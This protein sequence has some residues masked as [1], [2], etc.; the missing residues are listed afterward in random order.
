MSDQQTF[1]EVVT[2]TPVR[3]ITL[4]GDA[5]VL[6]L[7]TLDNGFDHTKPNTFGPQTIA[8]LLDVVQELHVRAEAG[9]IQAVGITGK[10]FIFAVGADLKAVA[11]ATSREQALEVAR[12]GHAA[13]GAIMDLPVPTFA[14]VNGAAMGGGV[15]IALSADYRSISAGVPAIAL[16]E[17]FLG[18]VPGWGGC[19]LLPNLVGPA[20]ALKVIIENPMNTNRML[21]GPQAFE[22]GMA[23]VMF[24]PAD[25]LEESLLWAAKVITGETTVERTTKDGNGISRDESEWSGAIK[26]AKGL[27]DLKTGG[28]SPAPYRALQL[29]AAARTATRDEAF[30]AEDEALADLVMGDELRAGLYSF[31]LVQRRAKRPAGAPDKALARKVTKVGIVGAGLM[32]SQLALLFAQRLEVPVVMTDLDEERVGQGRGLRPRRG[33]QA[34]RQA[35]GQP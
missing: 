10:P 11:Q 9:E 21:K 30:A 26:A 1:D 29:V 34:A 4:P 16:P 33:R 13:F 28:K 19:Y 5:G 32:A 31:D 6:A 22:L 2:H 15:E 12:A 3:D 8:G 20:N 17:T 35:A 23:D 7:I 14:F 18:L 27:V 25:F 24:A